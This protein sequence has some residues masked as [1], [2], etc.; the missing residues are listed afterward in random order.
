MCM[1]HMLTS[2][3]NKFDKVYK[4]V[5]CVFFRKISYECEYNKTCPPTKIQYYTYKISR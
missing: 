2:K 3:V 1:I 4:V 5:L